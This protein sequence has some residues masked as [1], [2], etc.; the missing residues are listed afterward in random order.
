[1]GGDCLSMM[2]VQT[3]LVDTCVAATRF[4][5][6]VVSPVE[7]HVFFRFV[8]QANC[9]VNASFNP[10]RNGTCPMAIAQFRGGF[11]RENIQRADVVQYPF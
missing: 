7:K 4:I 3:L 8:T 5:S 1:M 11:L 10:K 2:S 9:F 6:Y